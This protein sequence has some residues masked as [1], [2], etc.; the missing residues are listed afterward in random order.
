MRT[1]V[2]NHISDAPFPSCT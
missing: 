1:R 2:Q